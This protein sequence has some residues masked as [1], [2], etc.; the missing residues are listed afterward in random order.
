MFNKGALHIE[1]LFSLSQYS[2]MCGQFFSR[3]FH[4]E[5]DLHVLISETLLIIHQ[6]ACTSQAQI[7]GKTFEVTNKYVL[8]PN[9]KFRRFAYILYSEQVRCLSNEIYTPWKPSKPPWKPCA[10]HSV[11][12]W[13]LGYSKLCRL[14]GFS[15]EPIYRQQPNHSCPTDVAA[16][17]PYQANGTAF[18]TSMLTFSQVFSLAILQIQIHS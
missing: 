14:L 1:Q 2:S 8:H 3:M 17:C 10:L 4:N 9:F 13:L 16:L 18:N 12:M 6:K 7:Q 5:M 15:I 11:T